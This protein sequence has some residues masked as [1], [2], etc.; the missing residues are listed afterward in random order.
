MN[1]IVFGNSGC[2]S[3]EAAKAFLKEK[4]VDFSY[5]DIGSD[6]KAAEELRKAVP[7]A[8]A[9]PVIIIDGQIIEGFDREKVQKA[10]AQ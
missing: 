5:K 6:E 9:V 1:V 4:G 10:F 2:G 8:A 7:D 3:C